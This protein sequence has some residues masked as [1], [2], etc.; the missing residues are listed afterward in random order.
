MKRKSTLLRMLVR[1]IRYIPN[2]QR[3][4]FRRL[5]AYCA[6]VMN[7]VLFFNFANAQQSFLSPSQQ[8]SPRPVF[9]SSA[10]SNILAEIAQMRSQ[11]RED[12]AYIQALLIAA[13]DLN[14]RDKAPIFIAEA[15]KLLQ[16][17]YSPLLWADLLL[18]SGLQARDERR[19]DAAIDTLRI[20]IDRYIALGNRMKTA[21]AY[22]RLG[23][24]YHQLGVYEL[25]IEYHVSALELAREIGYTDIVFR[26]EVNV[27]HLLIVLGKPER[28]LVLLRHAESIMPTNTAIQRKVAMHQ[29][30]AEALLQRGVLDSAMIIV[31]KAIHLAWQAE[32]RDSLVIAFLYA[33]KAQ[34]EQKRGNSIAAQ[35]M[36]DS[37]LALQALLSFHHDNIR[38]SV[39][40][41]RI[42]TIR[43]EQEHEP[44]RKKALYR[45][46]VNYAEPALGNRSVVRLHRLVLRSILAEAYFSLGEYEIAFIVQRE[47]IQLRDSLFRI[48]LEGHIAS[49]EERLKQ[50]K[51]EKE[52]ERL[53]LV[54]TEQRRLQYILMLMAIV[55]IAFVVVL[56]NRFRIKKRSESLVESMNIELQTTN[57]Q[58]VQANTLLNRVN[59]ELLFAQK[60]AE[61][62]SEMKRAFIETLS[63]EIRTPLT[64]VQGYAEILMWDMQNLQQREYVERIGNAVRHLL[65]LFEDM[66][67][68]AKMQ[69][70]QIEIDVHPVSLRDLCRQVCAMYEAQALEKG[71]D[72][73]FDVSPSIVQHLLLDEAK[74]RLILVNLLGNAVKFT[75]QGAVKLLIAPAESHETREEN[76]Y[77][78]DTIA[79]IVEDTGIGIPADALPY[80]FDSF[81]HTDL[82][83]HRRYGGLGLGLAI[84]KSFVDVMKGTISVQS[85]EGK[86]TAFRVILPV[87]KVSDVHFG[88]QN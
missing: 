72:L 9:S 41:A 24:L 33:D 87:Q 53:R 29:Y 40:A 70:N 7:M 75:N 43:A 56:W 26:Q 14:H 18:V 81:Q 37:A 25:A 65:L 30:T 39:E 54:N 11:G 1:T 13:E 21:H 76:Q 20:A 48:G 85:T 12:S 42:M 73:S 35:Q 83:I 28:A 3:Y 58:L 79:F 17:R 63:H 4:R 31:Q 44:T 19:F 66:L 15:R 49:V 36:L 57:A 64:T 55:L 6:G 69:T 10:S 5:L 86:G 47:Y 82:E 74:I 60:R 22:S 84:C 45:A 23:L 61:E 32:Y 2:C 77:A 80:I 71:I 34:I 46:A 78:I 51:K 68:L 52:I 62:V 67:H 27:A 8:S 50:N 38:L 59:E 88:E 16:N